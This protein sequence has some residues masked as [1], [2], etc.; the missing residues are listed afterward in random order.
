VVSTDVG[1]GKEGQSTHLQAMMVV[2]GDCELV[3]WIFVRR[4]WMRIA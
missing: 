2:V 4:V 1:R 3:Y